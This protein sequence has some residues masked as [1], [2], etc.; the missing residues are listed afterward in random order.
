MQLNNA[1]SAAMLASEFRLIY[2]TAG[3]VYYSLNDS[4]FQHFTRQLCYYVTGTS[5]LASLYQL[6]RMNI[7]IDIF[8]G[9][10][11]SVELH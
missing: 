11:S 9:G 3:V 5:L 8:Q 2:I 4:Q 1:S 6:Y 10:P 7:L